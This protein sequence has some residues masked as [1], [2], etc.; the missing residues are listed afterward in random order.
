MGR[1]YKLEALLALVIFAIV[2]A[3]VVRANPGGSPVREKRPHR[4][5]HWMLLTAV[6]AVVWTVFKGFPWFA[7]IVSAGLT[8]LVINPYPFVWQVLEM[9][10]T[11]VCSIFVL[12]E[13]S[14]IG[15][16]FIIFLLIAPTAAIL[17]SSWVLRTCVRWQRPSASSAWVSL[18][19]LPT[20][21]AVW[22]ALIPTG[23]AFNL[24]LALSEPALR[25]VVRE[26]PRGYHD[27]FG[28]P[29]RFGLFFAE[30]IEER[31]GCVLW[32]RGVFMFVSAGLAYIPRKSP[33][34]WQGYS[35]THV[36][37]PWWRLQ[38]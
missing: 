38:N 17:L 32:E 14:D 8:I 10:T 37:G 26:I 23:I 2:A 21:A 25:A 34:D 7:C 1:N 33:P 30:T 24:R 5:W 27:G 3:L 19:L 31:E 16:D 28:E 35:F 11:A 18:L 36:R 12:I 4:L 22:F 15:G 13:F 9:A 20:A 29:R 6:V